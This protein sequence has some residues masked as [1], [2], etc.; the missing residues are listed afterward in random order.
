[1]RGEYIA[2]ASDDGSVIIT[3]MRLFKTE[4]IWRDRAKP[5]QEF[6]LCGYLGAFDCLTGID[7]TGC[8]YFWS[9]RPSLI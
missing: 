6:S 5:K 1:V 7:K 2:S 3:Y 4:K 9:V 8:V